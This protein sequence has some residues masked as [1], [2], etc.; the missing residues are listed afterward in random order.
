[1]DLSRKPPSR[2]QAVFFCFLL[3]LSVIPFAPPPAKAITSSLN[4]IVNSSFENGTTPNTPYPLYW[5]NWTKHGTPDSTITVDNAR[6]ING[7]HSAK[8]DVGAKDIGFIAMY[9]SL[10]STLR[11]SNL[12]DRPDGFDFWFYLQPKYNGM[13]DFRVRIL[14]GENVA[15]LNYV[16]DPSPTLSYPNITDSGTG[17]PAA[18]NLLLNSNDYVAGGGWYHF[19]SNL[20]RDWQASGLDINQFFPRIQ[21]DAITFQTGTSPNIQSFAEIVW[22]DNVK[23]YRD[24]QTP[25]HWLS[26]TFQD[27]NGVSV[28]PYAEWKLFNSSDKS[29]TYNFGDV[30]L[31]EGVYRLEV[32][33]P[34]STGQSPEPFRIFTQSYGNLDQIYTIQLSM[35]A[36]PNSPG[37]YVAF[38]GAVQATVTVQNSTLLSFT[39][40]GGPSS[41]ILVRTGQR[42]QAVL[43]DQTEIVEPQWTY[44]STNGILKISSTLLGK[45][46]IFF[47]APLRLPVISFVNRL[48][49]SVNSIVKTR[50]LDSTLSEITYSPNEI[51]N[52]GSYS[53]EAYYERYRIYNAPLQPVTS[54]NQYL[55]IQLAMVPLNPAAGTYIAVN[56]TLASLTILE[57]SNQNLTVRVEGTGA[58]LFVAQVATKPLYIEKDGQKI[59]WTY[60]ST[61][62]TASFE[63]ETPGTFILVFQE[64]APP[65]GLPITYW[66]ALGAI[67]AAAL[68]TGLFL[69]WN[70]RRSHVSGV[71]DAVKVK[72]NSFYIN[73]KPGPSDPTV[74]G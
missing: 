72:A 55:N 31:P 53:L 34:N 2:K 70:R 73:R 24:E 62:Q 59:F 52:P 7:T 13:G 37:N 33:Y 61:S 3:L 19:Q 14:F 44:D 10:P 41:T 43:R 65:L 48:G 8:L 68:A 36:L 9:Q 56:S 4:T 26:F 40:S 28:N 66:L 63:T 22:I 42:P 32:Y 21:F 6:A 50:I 54:Q 58:L 38:D 25:A 5:G 47:T 20:R 49:Q 16:F 60:D 45:F 74:S 11:F 35:I 18:V 71:A 23:M 69:I 64:E 39:A 27:Q 51:V 67:V 15:E 29:I 46:S 57:Q 30:T 1:M 17:R 12:S